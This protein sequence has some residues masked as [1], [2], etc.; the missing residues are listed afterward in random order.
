MKLD[1]KSARVYLVKPYI[2]ICLH[3][4]VISFSAQGVSTSNICRENYI[5]E[6]INNADVILAGIVKKIEQKYSDEKYVALVEIHRI[7]K[8]RK[9]T[10]ELF[11]LRMF[12]SRS[13]QERKKTRRRTVN[14]NKILIHNFGNKEICESDVKP[15]DVRV[16]LLSEENG[17]LFVNSS[18]IQPTSREQRDLNS[19]FD[20]QLT[21]R[22]KWYSTPCRWYI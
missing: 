10:Y 18:L 13:E 16:F 1:L 20:S 6:N 11:N 19:L 2:F 12:H 15:N 9:K 4:V 21:D 17:K 3:L 22:C 7:I 8:G 14:G 5:E